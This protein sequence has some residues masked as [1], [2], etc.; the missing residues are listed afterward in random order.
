MMKPRS[1]MGLVSPASQGKRTDADPLDQIRLVQQLC[2]GRE[3]RCTFPGRRI[4]ANI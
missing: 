1:L 2:A 3:A 4:L